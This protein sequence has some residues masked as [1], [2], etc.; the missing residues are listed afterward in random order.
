MSSTIARSQVSQN[1]TSV[2]INIPSHT[3]Q[4]MI[5]QAVEDFS[6]N[7]AFSC[8]DQFL[9]FEKT[10]YYTDK[11]A[12][13]FQHNWQLKKGDHVA[14]M[15]PNLLQFPVVLFALIKLGCIF[16]NINPLYASEEIK[17]ILLNSKS[18]AV[19]ILDLLAH[20]LEEI[21]TECPEVKNVMV[22]EIT[23]LYSGPKKFIIKY[24]AKYLKGMKPKFNSTNFDT[25]HKAIKHDFIAD[26]TTTKVQPDDIACL[27]YSS[28]TTGVP[29]GVI[30]LHRNIVSNIY[31]VWSWLGTAIELDRQIIIGALPLY[32]IFG[33]TANLFTFY[34]SGSKH[35]LIPN[36]KDIPSL[37][38]VLKRNP[39]T[40]FNSINT[41]YAALLKN[42]DFRKSSFPSFKYSLSGGMSTMEIVA[43]EWKEVTNIDIKEAYG[44]SEMSPAAC[45]NTFDDSPYNGTVGHPLPNTLIS[46]RDEK[47]CEAEQGKEGE[48]WLNGPQKS[49]GFW[50]NSKITTE[51]F[52]EDGWLKTGDI[53][54]I[55]KSGRLTIS[56]RIKHMLIISGFNV[57]PKEIEN[58]L[59]KHTAID[60]AAIIGA[61]CLKTGETPIAYI[62]LK[63][64]E[65]LSEK[66]VIE[67][68]KT[69]LA[70][71]KKPTKVFF[72]D[73]L[74]KSAVGKIDVKALEKEYKENI[75]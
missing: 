40:V 29:K 57:F 16:I 68:C 45:I 15:L 30:L 62:V 10:N 71:Y 8:H 73:A 70:R 32:H 18:K 66:E 22:S 31:Q 61:P 1:T 33:L 36:P 35:I 54:F 21:L 20:H 12:A 74:P 59:L 11:V 48:I 24:A 53:G 60:D 46:I 2:N 63:P 44:L 75:I 27:Q 38:K 55:D 34:F 7:H 56:G 50:H 5:K 43:K 13:Y 58:T 42:S 37:V 19:I 25:F 47:G 67:Y 6:S 51:H 69:K 49:P 3:L 72:K 41:L 26:Y 64:G 28:G 39:F 52:T 65:T 4:D 17:H 9:T 23:D 14:I